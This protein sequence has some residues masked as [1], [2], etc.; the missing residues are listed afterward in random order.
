[1]NDN[2][3]NDRDKYIGGSDLPIILGLNSQKNIFEFAKE[4]IGIINKE[5]T[6]SQYTHYG[7]VMED[8]IRNYINDKF[9]TNYKPSTSIVDVLRGNCDG[10]DEDANIP[11]IEIKTFGKELNVDY[12][13]YQCQF[14]ML[15]FDF[16]EINLIGYKRPKNFYTGIDY[17][18]DKDDIFFNFDFDE[19]NLEYHLIKRDNELIQKIFDK[20]YNFYNCMEK[21]KDNPRM[22]EEEFNTL[23]YGAPIVALTNKL[24][25]LETSLQKYKDLEEE[26]KKLK[27]KIYKAFEN[28]DIL[29]FDTGKIKITRVK[30][31]SYTKTSI[32][33]KKLKEEQTEIYEKYKVDKVVNRNGYLLITKRNKEEE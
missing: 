32:D 24:Q 23:L 10:M 25:M 18:I 31:T 1:M 19:K 9:K 27:E 16:K 17:V 28:R 30:N 12:Y 22:S 3:L 15:L 7:Q 13:K 26:Y 6:G 4:K 8:K 33:T 29:S 21:L 14:Y 11:L 2:I 5:D 20:S